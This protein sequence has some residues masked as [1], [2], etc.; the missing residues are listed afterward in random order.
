M[1]DL[2]NRTDVEL[3][4]AW[5]GSV[6]Y[7]MAL[8]YKVSLAVQSPCVTFL[9]CKVFGKEFRDTDQSFY[10]RHNVVCRSDQQWHPTTLTDPCECECIK[11]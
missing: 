11:H 7:K 9:Q 1:P 10:D 8:S 2:S 5:N 6:H 3:A 4:A